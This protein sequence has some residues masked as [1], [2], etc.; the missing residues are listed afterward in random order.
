[1]RARLWILITLAGLLAGLQ[2]VS[3]R[4][5]ALVLGNRNYD[6]LPRVADATLLRNTAGALRAEGFR[7]IDGYNQTAE[8]AID[9]LRRFLDLYDD[10]DRAVIVLAGHFGHAATDSWLMP[11][12]IVTP[13]RIGIGSTGL[14]VNTLLAILAEKPGRTA[15]F[16]GAHNRAVTVGRGVESGLGALTVP[17]GV[18][19]ATG[20]PQALDRAIRANFLI[21]G[22]G[23]ASA[24]AVSEG[25]TGHGFVADLGGLV[26]AA[27]SLG[28]PQNWID[29]GYWQMAYDLGTEAAM[30]QYLLAFPSGR[31]VAEAEAWIDINVRSAE[32]LARDAER[33]LGLS[34]DRRQQIQGDLTYLGYSTNG[35]D[36]IFGRGTR[37]AIARWQ[38]RNAEP[39]TGYLTA[40]QPAR[41]ADQ[42]AEKRR[43]EERED[44]DFWASS[45]ARAGEERGLRRYL[46]RYPEGLYA[47]VA[48]ARL[49]EIDRGRI[50]PRERALWD[51]AATDRTEAA[52]E[53]YLAEFP[54]GTFAD[55]ARAALAELEAAR[56]ADAAVQAARRDE[57]A[58]N[59]NPVSRLLA[60]RQLARSGFDPG[61]IDGN[62]DRQTRRAIRRYQ[63]S[64]GLTVSG[65][66]TGQTAVRLIAEIGR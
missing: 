49:A 60:E 40:G 46:R 10:A 41:I 22:Q 5:V 66:L 29:D 4:D 6:A 20:A 9:R 7:V 23:F 50:P 61:T 12:N 39:A 62:F 54:D 58:Q 11:S 65:Y 13:D 24:L 51:A 57:A 3:A 2:P 63:E 26:P 38:E 56:E 25:I 36:G 17:Q 35:V 55:E 15:L 52:Y 14:S 8:Q 27:G 33:R 31:H 43:R 48:R 28:D 37:S 34:R 59:L 21:P 42:A 44:R 16:L 18:F 32:E 53:A 1:M 19:V 64:R 47:D 30:R 45:G